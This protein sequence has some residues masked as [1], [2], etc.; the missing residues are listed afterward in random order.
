LGCDKPK[1]FTTNME[2]LQVQ[3][4]GQ[5]PKAPSLMDFELKFSDCPGDVRKIVRADKAFSQCGGNIKKGDKI[6]AEIVFYQTE[7]NTRSDVVR[8]GDCP[9]Q[10]DPKDEANYETV[11]NC[12][13]VLATGA[14]VGVHCDKTRNKELV[15]KCPWL[16]RN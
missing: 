3:R 4:F 9:L 10:F 16:R 12:H 15:Q 7:K 5:D 1:H 14:A 2:V 11:Q 13:E 8:L 6:E